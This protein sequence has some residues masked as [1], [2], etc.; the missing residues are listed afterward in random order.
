MLNCAFF[1]RLYAFS[2]MYVYIAEYKFN[3][4]EEIITIF[5]YINWT[6]GVIKS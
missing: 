6:F 4:L 1:R 3:I 5:S 2:C